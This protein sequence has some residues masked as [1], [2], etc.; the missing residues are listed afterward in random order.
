LGE[1]LSLKRFEGKEGEKRCKAGEE[2]GRKF[3]WEKRREG[4]QG[5]NYTPRARSSRK[6]V[7]GLVGKEKAMLHKEHGYVSLKEGFKGQSV[8][9]YQ[10]RRTIG[11]KKVRAVEQ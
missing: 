11:E 8:P 5:R 2:K 9:E 4:S 7:L 6:L 1:V 3:Y 10:M